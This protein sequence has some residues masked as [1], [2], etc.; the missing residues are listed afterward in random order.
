MKIKQR[1]KRGA[2]KAERKI[3]GKPKE[4][5]ITTGKGGL[6]KSEIKD[7]L[8]TLSS[9]GKA[10]KLPQ[11][12]YEYHPPF[13]L[14]REVLYLIPKD[15]NVHKARV[16]IREVIK[17]KYGTQFIVD[18][19]KASSTPSISERRSISKRK[20]PRITPKTPKLR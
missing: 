9:A 17:A 4:V 10:G 14:G 6:T 13:L 8:A 5:G 16:L 7:V 18:G 19:S 2:V 15:G 1:I 12:S 20:S 3:L 11:M